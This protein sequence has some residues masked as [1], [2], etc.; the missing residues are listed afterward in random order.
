MRGYLTPENKADLNSV[1]FLKEIDKYIINFKKRLFAKLYIANFE[2][3]KQYH[4]LVDKYY[5]RLLP[6]PPPFYRFDKI[7]KFTMV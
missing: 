5:Q 2:F 4:H 7:I 3:S 1:K 6:L